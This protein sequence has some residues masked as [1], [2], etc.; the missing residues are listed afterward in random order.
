MLALQ[1][2]LTEVTYARPGNH[3]STT[4][5]NDWLGG[6]PRNAGP[7]G[8]WQVTEAMETKLNILLS[9]HYK[10][11]IRAYFINHPEK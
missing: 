1:R 6:V 10:T 7:H 5:F 4:T 8:H 2:Y 9:P 11:L 3:Y